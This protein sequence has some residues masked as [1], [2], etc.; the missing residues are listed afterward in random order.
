VGVSIPKV[1]TPKYLCLQKFALTSAEDAQ[2]LFIANYNQAL[3]ESGWDVHQ[4]FER[5]ESGI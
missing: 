2:R 4:Q 1:V 5:D 3:S